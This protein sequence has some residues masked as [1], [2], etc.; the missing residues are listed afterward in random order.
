MCLGEGTIRLYLAPQPKT[1]PGATYIFS[2]RQDY[3][4]NLYLLN[5][6][7][8]LSDRKLLFFGGGPLPTLKKKTTAFNLISIHSTPST[9]TRKVFP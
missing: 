4:H 9:F 5:L 2:P 3:R 6:K 7:S 1:H 8:V